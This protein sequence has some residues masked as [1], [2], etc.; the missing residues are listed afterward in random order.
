[1][2]TLK[3]LKRG[4]VPSMDPSAVVRMMYSKGKKAALFF[5]VISAVSIAQAA[6]ISWS[7][8]T[9]DYTNA[10]SWVGGVVPG[11]N[12]T[13]I[14]DSGSNNVVRIRV[15]NPDW[16]VNQIRAGNGAGDGAFTQDGQAVILNGANSGTGF[17]TPFRLGTGATNT[18]IY[19]LNGGSIIYTNG[20]FNVGEIG[21]GILNINGVR[22]PE[23]AILL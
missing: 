22:S 5:S 23:T 14:N 6:N 17:V 12:D 13:A 8:G 20:S 7:G 18:G 10:P 9:A 1:M 3:C 16:T 21:T 11:P 2:K 4:V 15:G 19:T